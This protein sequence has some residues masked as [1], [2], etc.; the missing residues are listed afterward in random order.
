MSELLL[1]MMCRVRVF[2]DLP[3]SQKDHAPHVVKNAAAL[4]GLQCALAEVWFVLGSP[5]VPLGHGVHVA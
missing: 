2:D 3:A 1:A 5:Y 4:Q